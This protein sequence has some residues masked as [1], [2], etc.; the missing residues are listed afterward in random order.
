MWGWIGLGILI[1]AIVVIMYSALIIS[2]REDDWA[3]EQYCKQQKEEN[4]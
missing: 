1:V 4:E 3:E 2:G